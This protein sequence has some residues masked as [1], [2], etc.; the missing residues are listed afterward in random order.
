VGYKN[1]RLTEPSPQPA[2]EAIHHVELYVSDH[3]E[4]SRFF[5][6]VLGFQALGT[7]AAPGEVDRTSVALQRDD[8]CVLLTAPLCATSEVAEHIRLHGDR[9]KNIAFSVNDVD[10]LFMRATAADARPIRRPCRW[11]TV[12]EGL[13]VSCIGTCGDLE[14]SLIGRHDLGLP[15]LPGLQRS[16]PDAPRRAAPAAPT[17]VGIALPPGQLER[18]VAFYV[19]ALGF[20]EVPGEPDCESGWQRSTTLTTSNRR[21]RL[22]LRET[23]PGIRVPSIARDAPRAR[24]RLCFEVTETGARPPW[25]APGTSRSNGIPHA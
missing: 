1:K 19:S 8:V 21:V 10:E 2:V 11:G 12:R 9:I 13:R 22:A 17:E 15:R 20:R 18:W 23:M 3:V 6:T 5:T 24:G 7:L 4:S 25:G 16:G 14:H